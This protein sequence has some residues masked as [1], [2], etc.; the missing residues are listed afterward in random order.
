MKIFQILHGMCHWETPF[1]SLDETFGRFP[2][3]CLFVEAPDYVTEQWGFNEFGIGDERFIQ[4][5]IPEDLIFDD[6]QGIFTDPKVL[7]QALE[8]AKENKCNKSDEAMNEFLASHPLTYTD[9]KQYS[10]T[11]DALNTMR[12]AI[13]AYNLNVELGITAPISYNAIGEQPV[14]WTYEDFRALYLACFNEYNT[15]NAVNQGY[16]TQ[17][18][19]CETIAEV[20]D[21]NI[22]YETEAE[23]EA[24]LAEEEEPEVSVEE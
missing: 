1:K 3:D 23:R 19:A 5:E 18:L 11:M 10:V 17:I 16:K 2:T 20:N 24:R 7:A 12:N 22:L 15:W 9:D 14:D 13:T 6:E 8:E 21:I 4:P